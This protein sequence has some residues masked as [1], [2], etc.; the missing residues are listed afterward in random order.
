MTCIILENI[1]ALSKL[2]FVW[3]QLPP[4]SMAFRVRVLHSLLLGLAGFS[5]VLCSFFY[6]TPVA[7]RYGEPIS[8]AAASAASTVLANN[9]ASTTAT[10]ASAS[11]AT[12]DGKM[13]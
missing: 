1:A 9:P 12:E 11:A 13:K 8:A 10:A 4:V 5:L 2:V 3:L 6:A 7:L